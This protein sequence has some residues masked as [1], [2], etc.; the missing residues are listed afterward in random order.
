[1]CGHD[2]FDGGCMRRLSLV[3]EGY[4]N[5]RE[6]TLYWCWCGWGAGQPRYWRAITS[7][8]ESRT[9]VPSLTGARSST[10]LNVKGSELNVNLL[11]LKILLLI[12]L[13]VFNSITLLFLNV[14][15]LYSALI[16]HNGTSWDIQEDQLYPREAGAYTHKVIF[17]SRDYTHEI[18][19]IH[20]SWVYT[21]AWRRSKAE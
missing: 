6:Q 2:I 5:T 13:T 14:R 17:T 3:R 10:A 19:W 8:L 18:P 7:R 12:T 15:Q 9:W 16:Q 1:M 21:V 20:C 11:L 4:A